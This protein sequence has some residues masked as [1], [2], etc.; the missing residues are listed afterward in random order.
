MLL[1]AMEN[2]GMIRIDVENNNY[3]KKKEYVY[4]IRF[5]DNKTVASPVTTPAPSEQV[6]VNLGNTTANSIPQNSEKSTP[7]AKK[8]TLSARR[9]PICFIG[10]WRRLV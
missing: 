9:R 8:V 2:G 1:K 4:S 6:R 3:S 10:R 5:R 7:M